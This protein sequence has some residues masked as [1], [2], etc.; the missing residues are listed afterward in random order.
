MRSI[1]GGCDCCKLAPRDSPL[2]VK[3]S[4]ESISQKNQT[5][6]GTAKKKQLNELLSIL[7]NIIRYV[8]AIL[9]SQPEDLSFLALL[10]KK[11]H[12]LL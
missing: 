9:Y 1:V 11:R 7:A 10:S 5:V 3:V 4:G 6:R 2:T 8:I 12:R